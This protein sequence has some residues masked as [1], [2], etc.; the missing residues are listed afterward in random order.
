M[1]STVSDIVCKSFPKLMISPANKCIVLFQGK[2]QGVCVSSGTS[3]NRVGKYSDIWDSSCFE[4][5]T[6]SVCLE[7]DK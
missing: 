3:T 6:G 4:D 7:N 1:K 5:F 2:D